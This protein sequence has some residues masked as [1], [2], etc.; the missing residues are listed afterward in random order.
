MTAIVLAAGQATRFGRCKRTLQLDRG[1]VID[2]DTVEVA[3]N[4]A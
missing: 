4:V 3:G 2:V 1:I